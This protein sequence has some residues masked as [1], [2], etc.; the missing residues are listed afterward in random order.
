MVFN[1]FSFEAIKKEIISV[2]RGVPELSQ[3]PNRTSISSPS[4]VHLIPTYR[5]H[6]TPSPAICLGNWASP[7]AKPPCTPGFAPNPL[8]SSTV[9]S[10]HAPCQCHHSPRRHGRL[11]T[12]APMPMPPR[13]VPPPAVPRP[14][15]PSPRSGLNN[16]EP[17]PYEREPPSSPQIRPAPPL[18]VSLAPRGS[19]LLRP[20]IHQSKRPTTFSTP[21]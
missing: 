17:S 3:I 20:Y 4:S 1:K 15:S 6:R 10:R 12:A 8:L 9:S 18:M 7:R 14:N 2:Y 5:R 16:A 19:T 21:H 11:A 13:L